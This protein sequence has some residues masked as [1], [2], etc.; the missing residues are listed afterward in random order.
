LRSG[1]AVR[2][3]VEGLEQDDTGE[4]SLIFMNLIDETKIQKVFL[5]AMD[6]FD[7]T[8]HPYLG[9]DAGG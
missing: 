7:S 9:R 6:V 8:P 1:R 4:L 5:K 3:E 2:D